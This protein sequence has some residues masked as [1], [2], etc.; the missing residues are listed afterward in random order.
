MNQ[1]YDYDALVITSELGAAE[2]KLVKKPSEDM[3]NMM[4]VNKLKVV[5]NTKNRFAIADKLFDLFKFET[6]N[7]ETMNRYTKPKKKKS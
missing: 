1:D 3:C 5:F 7:Y 6:V 2:L 4:M